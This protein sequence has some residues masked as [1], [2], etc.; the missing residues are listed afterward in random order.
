MKQLLIKQGEVVV[1]QIPAPSCGP[2]DVLVQV[3][4]SLISTGTEMAGVIE[5]GKSLA[6]RAKSQPENVA[7]VLDMVKRQG[8]KKTFQLV[9]RALDSGLP[10]GYSVAGQVIGL[11]DQVTGLTIGDRVA[12]AG[13]GRANHAEVVS[14]PKNL[15]VKLPAKLGFREA[16]S[17]TLGSIALQGV[18]QASPELGD[19]VVV[20]GLGLIGLITVQLLKANGCQVIGID[21]DS[22]RRQLAEQLGAQV[23]SSPN[24]QLE[25]VLKATDGIGADKVIITAAT[26]SDEP[27]NAAMKIIRKKGTVVVVGA[28]G[29][30]LKRSPFYEKEADLKISCSYG[31]GRYDERYENQGIDYPIGYVRWTENR[32]MAS[33]LE[34]VSAGQVKLDQIIKQEYLIDEAGQAYRD[35]KT[36]T[37]KP[38]G[39][40]IKYPVSEPADSLFTLTVKP[41]KPSVIRVGLIGAG[42]FATGMHL[43]N[44]ER[45]SDRFAITGIIDASGV[46]AKQ[47]AQRYQAKYAGTDYRRL[48]SAKDIDLVMITTRHHL[49][50]PIA[51][52]ALKA[53]KAVFV[54]KPMALNQAQLDRL[55][56]IIRQ[57]KQLYTVGFNRRFS[58]AAKAIKQAIAHR[59]GPIMAYYRM[60]AGYLP[61]EHWVHGSEGGGR[62]IGE[63]CHIFDLFAFL[64]GSQP[65]S[66]VSQPISPTTSYYSSQDNVVTTVKYADG[67]VCNLI[68]TALGHPDQSKEYLELFYDGRSIV[69]DDYRTLAGYGL[70]LPSQPSGQDKGHYQE[71][72]ELAAALKSGQLPIPLADLVSTTQV[73]FLV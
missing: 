2:G 44:L 45:L 21:P 48:L 68:Y 31:P 9:K 47:V 10:T 6:S 57:T 62:I 20:A 12:C 41:V 33:Y 71:L 24:D 42:G 50:A 15:V 49:H 72:I 40:L 67:S 7:L 39:A 19:R 17:V 11:G 13:A 27:I 22:Q 3:H 61:A 64:T 5:S 1:D 23:T 52:A 43:P 26:S 25:R 37:D 58:P 54:E 29:L 56:T 73:S 28:I 63:A 70:T 35:L 4:Y 51:E 18:R 66:L 16:A 38:L 46:V 14:V 36:S 32:N 60:N 55:V 69:M 8:L 59:Q 34:L 30:G 65:V 53:G